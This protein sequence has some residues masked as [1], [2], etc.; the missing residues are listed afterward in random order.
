M[1]DKDWRVLV[2]DMIDHSRYARAHAAGLDEAAFVADLKTV[3]AVTRC[4]E[5]I[6]EAARSIPQDIRDRS[7][8]IPWSQI[9]GTRH[10]LAHHYGRVDELILWALLD[11][12]LAKL[13]ASL[14]RLLDAP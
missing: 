8:E 11:D 2:Q 3:H 10:I 9:V 4:V 12:G 1:P 7:P 6:G 14:Q 13:E 5:I